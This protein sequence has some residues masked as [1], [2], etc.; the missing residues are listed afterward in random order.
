MIQITYNGVDITGSV[1]VNRCFHDMYAAG[2][3]DTLSLRANDVKNLWDSWAPGPGDEI[4]VDFDTVRTGGMFVVKELQ[5]AAAFAVLKAKGFG[6]DHLR[7]GQAGTQFT[8]DLAE[9]QIG[10]T[11]HRGKEHRIFYFYISNMH[12]I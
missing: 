5:K 6:T 7:Y 12:K 1:S 3:S 4:R 9:S 2:Q 8:A 11:G 10:H